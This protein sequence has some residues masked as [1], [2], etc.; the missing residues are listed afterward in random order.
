LNENLGTR[1]PTESPDGRWIAFTARHVCRPE[2]LPVISNERQKMKRHLQSAAVLLCAAFLTAC[3]LSP[4]AAVRRQPLPGKLT[5]LQVRQRVPWR[6]GAIVYYTFD[7]LDSSGKTISECGSATYVER[8]LLGWHLRGGGGIFCTPHA[9]SARP[10]ARAGSQGSLCKGAG[11]RSE[12]YGLVTDPAAVEV[13]VTWSDGLTETVAL[14]NESYLVVRADEVIV[15]QIEA[16]DATGTVVATLTMSASAKPPP[17]ASPQPTATRPPAQAPTSAFPRTI[18]LRL[19]DAP[20]ADSL[21][22]ESEYTLT[23]VHIREIAHT[24]AF[25]VQPEGWP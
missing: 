19:P 23:P 6:G 10:F 21:E 18:A 13:R 5:D 17:P 3:A 16:L 1:E 15:E 20:N 8:D 24:L 2:D 22:V 9:A 7:R 4:A 25:T 14:V 12:T 11:L